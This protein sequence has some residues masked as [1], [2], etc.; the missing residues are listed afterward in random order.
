MSEMCTPIQAWSI[1]IHLPEFWGS[2]VVGMLIGGAL[3]D[4]LFSRFTRS[5]RRSS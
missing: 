2:L 3:A 1:A 4:W 5:G